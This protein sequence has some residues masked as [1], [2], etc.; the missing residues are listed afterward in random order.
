MLNERQIS[1]GK[2]DYGSSLGKPS[3]T[4][5]ISLKHNQELSRENLCSHLEFAFQELV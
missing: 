4:R 5:K 2:M 3:Q 1:M